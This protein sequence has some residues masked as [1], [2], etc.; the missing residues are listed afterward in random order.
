M[1]IQQME[2]A[3][4]AK[5]VREFQKQS[6]QMD[7]TVNFIISKLCPYFILLGPHFLCHDGLDKNYKAGMLL[8]HI[9]PFK[10]NF[11]MIALKGVNFLAVFV[12][13]KIT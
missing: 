3:K 10:L 6:A 1:F 7:M 9:S 11:G 13:T 4:Q 12:I 2:P 8:H 5:V